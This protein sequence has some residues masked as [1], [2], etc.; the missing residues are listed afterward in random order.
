M[1]IPASQLTDTQHTV[2]WLHVVATNGGHSPYTKTCMDTISYGYHTDF[3]Q[4]YTAF[5]SHL[6]ASPSAQSFC[7]SLVLV[8]E[9]TQHPWAITSQ[10][11]DNLMLNGTSSPIDYT[12]SYFLTPMD[13]Y[14]VVTYC[15]N[16]ILVLHITNNDKSKVHRSKTIL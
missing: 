2:Y 14:P 5:Q 4:I 9:A 10:H 6:A 3:W 16:I 1:A 11:M 7:Y 15:Y 13:G 8:Q 12:I